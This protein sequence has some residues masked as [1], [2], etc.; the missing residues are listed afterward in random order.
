MYDTDLTRQS[1]PSERYRMLLGTAIS[2]FSSNNGFII[3]NVLQ[4]DDSASWFTL[5]DKTSGAVKKYAE[6][7]LPEPI[8]ELFGDLVDMRNRIIHGFRI[9]NKHQEQ[10]IATKEKSGHQFEITED[11][12]LDFIRKNENLSDMLHQFRGY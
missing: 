9:T 7:K 2:V 10:V 3:E 8:V 6:G 1:L 5:I 4:I 12:L 11:Y